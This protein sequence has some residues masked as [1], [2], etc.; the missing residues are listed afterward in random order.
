MNEQSITIRWEKNPDGCTDISVSGVEDGQTLFREAFLSLD[1]LPSL[2]DI[3]ERE[4]SGESAGKSATTAFLAQLIG[5]IRKSDKTSGQIVSEQ[6]QN[7]KFPLTDLVAIRKFA[8]IAG[9]KF[10]EQKFRNRREF[11]LYV[12]SLMKDNFEKSV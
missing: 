11:R 6:I 8:E 2:H 1:R 3:T 10:D 4:T 12:Q 9:I 7:S 5:I